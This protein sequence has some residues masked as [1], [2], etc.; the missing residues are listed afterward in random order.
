[1]DYAI[2]PQSNQGPIQQN[3]GSLPLPFSALDGYEAFEWMIGAGVGGLLGAVLLKS[4]K[5]C[6]AG[7]V[8][9]WYGSQAL[10]RIQNRIR[11]AR[12]NP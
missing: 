3:L 7:A 8:L 5:A 9:G 10:R 12:T 2:I 6:A 11:N 4:T 1:M